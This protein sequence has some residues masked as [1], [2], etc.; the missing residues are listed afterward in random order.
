[1]VKVQNVEGVATHDIP[2]SC[3]SPLGNHGREALTG[4]RAG[5]VLSRE[6]DSLQG[7]DPVGRWGR[8]HR[9]RQYREAHRGPARSETLCMHGC[10]LFGNREVPRSPATDGEA[11][12]IGK[13]KDVRR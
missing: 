7:A 4:V 10:T 13:S 1:M 9:M 8:P 2:E 6:S 12:R 5:R 11:G 3:A